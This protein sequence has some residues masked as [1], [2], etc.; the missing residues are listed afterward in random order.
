MPNGRHRIQDVHEITW[1]EKMDWPPF[2]FAYVVFAVIAVILVF[3]LI[4]AAD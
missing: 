2:K 4:V 3:L 1:P